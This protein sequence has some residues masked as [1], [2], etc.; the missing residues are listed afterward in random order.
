MDAVFL[1]SSM[2]LI[3]DF[4]HIFFTEKIKTNHGENKSADYSN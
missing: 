2:V 4:I 3:G 1:F